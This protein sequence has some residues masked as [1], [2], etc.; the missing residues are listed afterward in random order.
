MR[1]LRNVGGTEFETGLDMKP[2]GYQRLPSRYKS[3]KRLHNH[4]LVNCLWQNALLLV[5]EELREAF[6]ALGQRLQTSSVRAEVSRRRVFFADSR[7]SDH[8]RI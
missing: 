7:H 5:S 1:A 4:S 6:I 3:V 8:V 2:G